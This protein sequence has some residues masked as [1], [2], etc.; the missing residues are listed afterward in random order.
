[1]TFERGSIVAEKRGVFYSETLGVV[2]RIAAGKLFVRFG[3]VD[4]NT[5]SAATG[6]S[7]NKFRLRSGWRIVPL[8]ATVRLDMIAT[9][10]AFGPCTRPK[11][12]RMESIARSLRESVMA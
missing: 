12:E 10:F 11:L 9:G 5:F 4:I 2:D 8:D 7:C 3:E 6:I 1:M